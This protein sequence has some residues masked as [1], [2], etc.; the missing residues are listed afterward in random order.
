MKLRRDIASGLGLVFASGLT[1]AL[2]L[3]FAPRWLLQQLAFAWAAWAIA[4]F[5]GACRLTAAS[6]TIVRAEPRL[7]W[8]RA[9]AVV[10]ICL[11]WAYWFGLCISFFL[12]LG[13]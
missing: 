1:M 4:T 9:L 3:G 8:R 11:L 10:A 12:F 7:L 6:I 5:L 13:R 2:Y